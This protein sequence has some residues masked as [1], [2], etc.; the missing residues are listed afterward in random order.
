MRWKTFTPD[1]IRLYSKNLRLEPGSRQ[2][3]A[4]RAADIWDS[5]ADLV[6]DYDEKIA[7]VERQ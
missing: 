1:A 5:I 7:A 6:E 4:F 2:G 3:D